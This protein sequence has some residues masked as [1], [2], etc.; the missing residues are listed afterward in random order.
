[1]MSID[2][3]GSQKHIMNMYAK[4]QKFWMNYDFGGKFVYYVYR[5]N[6]LWKCYEMLLN[7]V[8]VIQIDNECEIVE[9]SLKVKVKVKVM[10]L[11]RQVELVV[12]YC[13]SSVC[14]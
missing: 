6:I 12:P 10:A 7:Y 8:V 14:C 2:E 4:D 13:V 5:M 1:M 3:V 11:C 9:L